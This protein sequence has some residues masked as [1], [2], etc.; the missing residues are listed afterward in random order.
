LASVAGEILRSRCDHL[1]L[2][3]CSK[4]GSNDSQK[5]PVPKNAVRL[6]F[7]YGSEKEDWVKDVTADFN[8]GGHKIK[9]GKPIYVDAVPEGSGECIDNII[10]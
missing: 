5:D 1:S 7:T 3:G 6:L 2:A 4:E 9:S 8:Q 10:R